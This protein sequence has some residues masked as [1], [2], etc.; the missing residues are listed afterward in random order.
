MLLF[1]CVSVF[2]SN[3]CPLM[4]RRDGVLVDWEIIIFLLC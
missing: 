4:I 2:F 3:G 1:C